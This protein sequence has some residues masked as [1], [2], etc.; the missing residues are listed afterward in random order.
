MPETQVVRIQCPNCGAQYETPIRTVI[1]VGQ[2]PQLRQALLSGQLNLAICPKCNQGGVI[3][4]PL[5]YHDPQAEF[6][7]VY[8]PPQVQ[9]PELERQR[10]IGEL[11]QEMMRNL[12]P[13][14]RKGY[15][16]NPRQFMNRQNLLDA[17]LGTMGISQEEL[18]R[19]RKKLK[20]IDQ[21]MVMAD[22]RKGLE[23]MIKGQD[24]QFDY[25]FFALLSGTLSQAESI[26]DQK[27][28][29]RM[30]ILYDNLL[31]LTTYGRRVAKQQAAVESLQ[32][33]STPEQLVDKIVAADPDEINAIAFAARPLLDYAFFQKL[34]ER[35]DASQGAERDRLTKVRDHL[36]DLTQKLDAAAEARVKQTTDL[37]QELLNSPSPRSAV[38]DHIA[39]LDETFMALLSLNMQNAERQGRKDVL[40]RLMMIYDEIMSVLEEGMPPEVQLVNDL[41]RAP[42]PDGTRALLRERQAEVTPEVLDLMD[43]LAEEAAA[44]SEQGSG[45]KEGPEGVEVSK[46]LRDIKA[47]AMLLV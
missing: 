7:A 35:L 38:R 5:V 10:M 18:D 31:E 27:S 25:E 32:E 23:M 45:G 15:F 47:Q 41:L 26:G 16:L 11:T 2:N 39:E 43:R 36:L 37:L 3:E 6:L 34:T 9:I 24:A 14:Q 13:D 21:L 30:G 1:D 12:P 4:A 40:Q 20:L 44:R 28:A 42:Y 8:F 46:R 17:V 29:E 33:I 19:Q 22:D